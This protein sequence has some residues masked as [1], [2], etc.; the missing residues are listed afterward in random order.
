MRAVP[1][2]FSGFAPLVFI[3]A[4]SSEASAYERQWQAGLGVGYAVLMNDGGTPMAPASSPGIGSS[5]SIT[6][7]ISDAFNLMAH[8]DMSAHPGDAPAFVYG[9]SIGISYV[10]DVL[11]W[12][13]WVGATVGG[14]GVSVLDP[15]VS[16][17]D[18]SCTNGR[19]GFS[20]PFGLDYQVSRTFSLGAM[21]RYGVLL[22]GNQDKVDQTVGGFI[23][24]QVLWGY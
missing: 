10:L 22:F 7:G 17:N 8:V 18:V 19:L 13:P 9:G 15:C 12:V 4:A 14:H 6:Y 24:A 16:T 3:V 11:R 1:A 20:I 2:F 23:R 5:L 21:G